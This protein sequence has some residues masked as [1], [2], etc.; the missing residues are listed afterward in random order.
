[1]VLS[2]QLWLRR[3][4]ADSGIVG[5]RVQM[6]GRSTEV[7]GVMPEGFIFPNNNS[8]FWVPLAFTQLQ[9]RASARLFNVVGRL[10]PDSTLE[11]AQADLEDISARRTQGRPE[12]EDNWHTRL[13]TLREFWFGWVRRP[14]L[15][16]EGA[17]ILVLLV[18]CANVST[19]LLARVPERHPEVVV[20]LLMGASRG[21]IVRQFLT[22]S[23]LLSLLGG[24]LGIP[25]AWWGVNSVAGLQPPLVGISMSGM[26]Q[27]NGI[28]GFAALLALATSLM[29]GLVPALVA[30]ASGADVRQSTAHRRSGK[31]SGILVSAQ[32][33]LALVLLISSGLLLN[34]FVRLLLADRGFDANGVLSFEYRIPAQDYTHRTFS[35]RGMPAMDFSPP[36]KEMRRVYERLK[37]LPGMES[38]AGSSARPVKGLLLPTATVILDGK[39]APES[40]EDRG[41]ANINYSW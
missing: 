21:R 19:L 31:L 40:S 30:F 5:R 6:N 1:V 15:T 37:A 39:P 20:R 11:Q 2:H 3:F 22:E 23:L 26:A 27:N 16:L 18:A 33:G 10:K 34:S 4:A 13:I 41:A 25:I 29:F 24:A 28:I 8:D 36:T 35:Y 14:L 32:V 17:V 38:V 9:L 12:Q 7:I